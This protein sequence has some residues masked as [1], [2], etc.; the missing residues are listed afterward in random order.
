MAC[1]SEITVILMEN[2]RPFEMFLIVIECFV[3]LETWI[4]FLDAFI[5]VWQ[6]HIRLG[7]GF[8]AFFFNVCAC[9][10]LHFKLPQIY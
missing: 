2:Y 4:L 1:I 5:H 7:I 9:L 3:Y 10:K 6:I 8:T